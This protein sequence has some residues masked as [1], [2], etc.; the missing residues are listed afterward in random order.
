MVRLLT[1]AAVCTLLGC[2]ALPHATP[3]HE[4]LAQRRWP[5]TTLRM[6]EEGRTKYATK[7]SGCHSL[8]M[9]ASRAPSDW[10]SMLDE[11]EDEAKL[12]A[13]DRELIERYLLTL[14]SKPGAPAQGS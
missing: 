6:L 5:G 1:T 10:P 2:A 8:P 13:Q 11:M 7:C 9:P 3:A 12:T 4:E 14:S